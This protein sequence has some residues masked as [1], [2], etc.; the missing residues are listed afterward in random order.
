MGKD[1]RKHIGLLFF[2][3]TFI[4]LRV[5]NFHVFS[6][7]F[8]DNDH[9]ID[10]KLCEVIS[11]SNDTTPFTSTTPDTV[12]Q[13]HQ[14]RVPVRDD[15]FDYQPTNFSCTLPESIRNRPPPCIG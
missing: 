2:L 12:I 15:H 11:E 1:F 8:D 4:V 9:Q 7:L 3:F 5:G 10:C 6:H 14:L 13:K